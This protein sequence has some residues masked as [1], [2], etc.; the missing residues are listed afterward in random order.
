MKIK[1]PVRVFME[2]LAVDKVFSFIIIVEFRRC[3]IQKE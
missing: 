3:Q 1:L 2:F